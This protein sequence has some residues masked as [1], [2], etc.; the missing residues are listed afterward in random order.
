MNLRLAD[1]SD[2]P[3]L[4]LVYQKIISNMNKENIQIWDEIY[5]CSFFEEDIK[6]RRLYVLTENGE[7]ASA[8]ALCSSNSGTDYIN[9]KDKAD[10]ALYIDRFGVNVNYLRRGVGSMM[11][12]KAAELAKEEGANCLRLFVVDINKPAIN[13]YI[14]N[15]FEKADGIYDEII[16]DDLVLHQFGFEIRT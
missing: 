15:G 14:K 11:L 2:L 12:K 13:L 8:F 5:P 7:I 4:K 6:K 16:D 10:K 3:E 1:L 9:W